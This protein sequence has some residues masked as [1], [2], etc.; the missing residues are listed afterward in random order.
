MPETPLDTTA[1]G[2]GAYRAASAALLD[3][4]RE[5]NVRD[6]L[7]PPPAMV[8]RTL[9]AALP[10]APGAACCD[11][12]DPVLYASSVSGISLASSLEEELLE[13]DVAELRTR[14][15]HLLEQC[16]QMR[17]R[18]GRVPPGEIVIDLDDSSSDSVG[19][20]EYAMLRRELQTN[21]A[22]LRR[23]SEY[24]NVAVAAQLGPM[25]GERV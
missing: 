20:G 21:C 12:P 3:A 11:F 18:C 4:V 15:L 6:E 25:C 8:R 22:L 23:C 5:L 7:P 16:K 2:P 1:E 10:D 14:I 17:A 9:S 13:A 24:L 19:H